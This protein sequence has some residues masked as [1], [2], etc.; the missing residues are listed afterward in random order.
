MNNAT[1]TRLQEEIAALENT[2]AERKRQLEQAQAVISL[3]RQPVEAQPEINKH[4]SPETKIA[5][6]RSLF[7]GRE[8]LYAKRFESKKTGKSGYQ[9][10]CKN[11]WLTGVCEKPRTNCGKCSRRDF[12]PV[13]DAVIRNHLAGF[14]PAQSDW[15]PPQPFVMGVYP[16]LQ[17]ET[18]HFLAVDFDKQ[19]W[20]ED[21][22]AFMESCRLAEI[23]AALER[24]RSGNGAHVW[25]F[26]EKA[27]PAVKA[28]KLGSLLMTR[29]LDRRP[30]IALDSFDRFFPNQDTLPKG[31]FGNLIAL[32]LQKAAREKNHSVFLDE[33]LTPYPDQWAFL[34]SVRR[35]GA[36]QLDVLVQAAEERNEL[37]PV[38]YAPAEIDDTDKPWQSPAQGKAALPA[39]PEPLPAFVE[40]VLADQIYVNHTGLPPV[41]RNRILRL[42]SF[43]N[44]EFYRA[45][46]M[47]LTT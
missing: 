27:V 19:S 30:E 22:K 32:P 35:V 37:L 36:E 9:P 31:G 11:E 45:Q 42:A 34:A 33:R 28:R 5:L 14:I 21:A 18:C 40:V 25:I 12:E 17:D 2:L 3:N 38:A 13:S 46:K 1:V 23:P 29:T 8:D 4:S 41:L 26:F 7:R 39:I 10:V 47:R 16:L 15:P 44:P 20:Q 6:F 24:S 43:S